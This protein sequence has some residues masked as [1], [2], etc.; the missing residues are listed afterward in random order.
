[1]HNMCDEIL[2]LDVGNTRLKWA[3]QKGEEF[4]PGGEIV[5]AGQLDAEQLMQ[6]S[7]DH[8]P[9]QVVATCVADDKVTE[10]LY[11]QIECQLDKAVEFVTAVTQ[12]QGITNAYLQP[13]QLGSDRW[14][15]LVAAHQGWP[16]FLCVIDA[17]S[18]LTVDLVRPDGQHLGGY[19]LPG[20]GMMQSCLL[21]RTAIPMPNGSE[22]IVPSTQP[23]TNTR[24]CMANGAL[25]AACGLIERTVLQLEQQCKETVQC[26]LTG[27][28]SQYVAAALT[29]PY[30]VEPNL[31]LMGLAHIVHSRTVTA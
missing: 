9:S 1:M 24:S 29:I 15:A 18:A 17:G 10:A 21:E 20:L 16:G 4:S 13:A 23:G 30:V 5:H 11:K 27:G 19:I 8:S 14:A 6:I 25:Q 22:S 31:V 3:W 26:L 2:L 28:D 12:A 7:R